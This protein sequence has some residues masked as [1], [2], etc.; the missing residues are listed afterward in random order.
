MREFFFVWAQNM[1]FYTSFHPNIS[2]N[3]GYF[4]ILII[5]YI[6]FVGNKSKPTILEFLSLSE[7]K[8]CKKWLNIQ[9]QEGWEEEEYN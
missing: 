9:A 4:R 5:F 8:T 3:N 2:F 6:S 1:T 7:V